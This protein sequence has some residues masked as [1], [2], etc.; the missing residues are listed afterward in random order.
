MNQHSNEYDQ[1]FDCMKRAKLNCKPSK[2]EKV[3][4]LIKH[5]GKIVKTM[6]N[7]RSS[8]TQQMSFVGFGVILKRL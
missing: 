3:R 2:C 5:L 1:V 7:A 6:W 4:V 8:K